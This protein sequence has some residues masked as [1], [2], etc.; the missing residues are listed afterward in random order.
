MAAPPRCH[1]EPVQPS[2]PTH[3]LRSVEPSRGTAAPSTTPPP[4]ATDVAARSTENNVT[5]L[6]ESFTNSRDTSL[7]NVAES[8]TNDIPLL[9]AIDAPTTSTASW[10]SYAWLISTIVHTLVMLLLALWTYGQ[11]GTNDGISLDGSTAE[12]DADNY[13]QIETVQLDTNDVNRVADQADRPVQ[14]DLTPNDTNLVAKSITT[15]PNAVPIDPSVASLMLSGGDANAVN[16][17][18]LLPGG[19]LGGRTPEGRKKYG[20]LY[21]ASGASEAA[22]EKA[23]RWLAEHQ[24]PNGSWSFNLD[25][26]PCNG[27]CTHSKHADDT[28]TPSTGATGLALLAFLGAGYTHQ[29]GPY[30]DTVKRGI[31]YLRSAAAESEFGYDWQQGSMYG[32][33]IAV[34]AL[35]EALS[36]T[37]N[38]GEFDSDLM[39]LVEKGAFFTSVAQHPNGSWGYVPGQPGDT[40]L[41][42]WQVLSLVGAKRAGINL[43][44]NTLP[45]AKAFL[46]GVKSEKNYSFGYQKPDPEL[47]TTAIALTLLMYLGQTPGYSPFDDAID[48]LAQRGPTLTNVYHDYYATMALHHWRHRDWDQWNAKLRDHLVRTQATQGHEAGSWHFKDKWGDIGGRLYTTAMCTLTLEVYYRHLPMYAKP[49]EFPL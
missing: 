22:V 43:R 41:T 16:H 25:L 11:R 46:M 31:Y 8:I 13:V 36:M 28:P 5:K 47:T 20:D 7:S 14:L 30:T 29:T 26:D 3:V 4:V 19:G 2:L 48:E 38:D 45:N 15:T 44:T 21:G 6:Q 23:L 37:A 12:S 40:T 17:L 1:S 24:R 10:R 35:A 34:M 27:R 42:G 33:G 18:T 39:H 9:D 32:H 49:A